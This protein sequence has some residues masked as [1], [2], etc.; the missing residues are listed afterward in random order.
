VTAGTAIPC[1][2]STFTIGLIA[3]LFSNRFGK[4]KRQ[5]AW[6][7]LFGAVA[8]IYHLSLVFFYKW[9]MLQSASAAWDVIKDLALP[10]ILSN[11]LAFGLLC[12][13]LE[14]IKA[15]QSTEMHAKQVEGELKVATD[16][17]DSMLPKIFPDYPGRLEFQIAA[18]MDPA[19]EVGGD[20]YDF[21]FLDQN[22]FVFLIADV[23]GKGVPA[24]LFMVVA[25]TL[26][27]NNLQSGLPFEEA[28]NKTNAKLLEDDRE[29]MFVTAWIGLVE[30]D[31]GLFHYINCVPFSL[32]KTLQYRNSTL[33]LG[34][35]ANNCVVS[36][37][38][39][40]LFLSLSSQFNSDGSPKYSLF[41]ITVPT[42]YQVVRLNFLQNGFLT[43]D[44]GSNSG[45]LPCV[46]YL[47]NRFSLS[48]TCDRITGIS[49]ESDVISL[50]TSFSP[51]LIW[52]PTYGTYAGHAMPITGYKVF[53]KT[54]GWWIF[55][56]TDYVKFLALNDNYS[57]SVRYTDLTAYQNEYGLDGTTFKI[58]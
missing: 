31:S 53:S 48:L 47:N 55:S 10:F 52:S 2:I 16:I 34:L 6:G 49:F 25:K 20:F 43:F 24:A 21:F 45:I 27:K 8:E 14:K 12:F 26:L 19:K 30:L 18:S 36:P 41:H 5:W 39:D 11:A 58:S 51:S 4:A 54:T 35:P 9:G 33:G 42:L 37:Q 7:L 56:H 3:G 17:Q 32:Y 50:M 15:F 22:H 38:S 40:P 1:A 46:N 28:V 29:R 44:I 57:P 23:S 13:L